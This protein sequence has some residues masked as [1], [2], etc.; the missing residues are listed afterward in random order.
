MRKL[1]FA[2]VKKIYLL[3]AIGVIMFSIA[4]GCSEV[5][6]NGSR[7]SNDEQFVMEYTV[8]NKTET[9][10]MQLEKDTEVEVVI[11]N[12]SGQLDVLVED[13]IGNKIY[14]GDD[15]SSGEFTLTITKSDEYTF[16]IK[17]KDAQGSVS[18]KVK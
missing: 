4:V 16:F 2:A 17:G 9:H 13:S 5:V 3:A 6:F 8:L 1:N 12:K 10:K 7:T 11:E 15:A 14:Q 18:F